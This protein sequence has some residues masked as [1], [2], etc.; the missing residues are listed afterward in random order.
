MTPSCVREASDPEARSNGS[1]EASTRP[2]VE[3]G[4]IVSWDGLEALLHDTLYGEVHLLEALELPLLRQPASLTEQRT[5][6]E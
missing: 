3:R 4:S 2:V 5:A 1:G 6:G